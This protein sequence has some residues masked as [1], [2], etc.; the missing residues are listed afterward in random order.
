MRALP[1]GKKIVLHGPSV[2]NYIVNDDL[3]KFKD[4]HNCN[5]T[6]NEKALEIAVKNNALKI[7]KFLLEVTDVDPS[8]DDNY[9]H[10]IASE[11]IKQMLLNHK[12]NK[13]KTALILR[14][15]NTI[16]TKLPIT[17][18]KKI[19]GMISYPT[20]LFLPKGMNNLNKKAAFTDENEEED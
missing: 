9:L 8:I 19:L 7:T 11:E 1:N 16:F 4:F 14:S 17:L 18:I 3:Q 10:S 2:S 13:I 15:N 5:N 12:N 6:T 20:N